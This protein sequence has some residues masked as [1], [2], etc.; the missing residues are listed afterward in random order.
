MIKRDGGKTG[1]YSRRKAIKAA[2]L[3]QDKWLTRSIRCYPGVTCQSR[4]DGWRQ[5]L[6]CSDQY[7]QTDVYLSNDRPRLIQAGLI[8][9]ISAGRNDKCWLLEQTGKRGQKTRLNGQNMAGRAL[10]Q[11]I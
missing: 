4:A 8:F 7:N 2:G 11:L 5:H 10:F 9:D 3:D 1:N 6:I